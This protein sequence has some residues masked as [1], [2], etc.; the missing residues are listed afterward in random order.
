MDVY[1]EFGAR[2][3][4]FKNPVN[5]VGVGKVYGIDNMEKVLGGLGIR[6]KRE[7][8]LTPGRLVNELKGFDKLIFKV[9]FTGRLYRKIYRLFELAGIDEIKRTETT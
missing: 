6:V 9:L 8:S 7:Y 3:S 4:K 1:T 2:A 5:E